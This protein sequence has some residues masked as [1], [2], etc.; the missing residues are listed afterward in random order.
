MTQ[1]DAIAVGWYWVQYFL[2][3][4]RAAVFGAVLG[5]AALWMLVALKLA[6]RVR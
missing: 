2:P 4:F 1:E 5:L 6:D 3:E